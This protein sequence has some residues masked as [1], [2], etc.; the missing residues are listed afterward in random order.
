MNSADEDP[1]DANKSFGIGYKLFILYYFSI[2]AYFGIFIINVFLHLYANIQ[3]PVTPFTICSL[4]VLVSIFFIL[5]LYPYA[6]RKHPNKLK[7]LFK[8]KV[9]FYIYLFLMTNLFLIILIPLGFNEVYLVWMWLLSFFWTGFSFGYEVHYLWEHVLT[10]AISLE[11]VEKIH[12]FSFIMHFFP[13]ALGCFL[14]GFYGPVYTRVET[15]IIAEIFSSGYA[16]LLMLFNGFEGYDEIQN[17]GNHL[18]IDSLRKSTLLSLKYR[19]SVF[20]I[21]GDFLL[22]FCIYLFFLF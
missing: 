19:I 6:N 13:F 18:L 9:I 4:I 1:K 3:F 15:L 14:V 2:S 8:K 10:G 16:L 12:L 21:L 17:T 22:G 5:P 11:F 7:V 20:V